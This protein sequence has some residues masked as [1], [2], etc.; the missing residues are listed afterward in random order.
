MEHFTKTS[1][2]RPPRYVQNITLP[3]FHLF[4]IKCQ[5]IFCTCN[6]SSFLFALRACYVLLNDVYFHHCCNCSLCTIFCFVGCQ[7]LV[8]Y[9]SCTAA[10]NL[11]V[12]MGNTHMQALAFSCN[13]FRFI[14]ACA[15]F[16]NIICMV[17]KFYLHYMHLLFFGNIPEFVMS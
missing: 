4:G 5:T 9:F 8:L 15:K 13:P 6:V 17:K 12:L 2:A 14:N 16:T 1:S 11:C 3:P 7:L 10:S